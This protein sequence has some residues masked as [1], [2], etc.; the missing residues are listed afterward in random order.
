MCVLVL[1]LFWGSAIAAKEPNRAPV[2]LDGRP[3]FLVSNYGQFDADERAQAINQHLQEVI[4]TPDRPRVEVAK[5]QDK[6]KQSTTILVN[7]QH[8]MTVTERDVLPG[9]SPEKQAQLWA[10]QIETA[11]QQAQTYRT[12]A[13]LQ[14]SLLLSVMVGAIALFFHWVIGRWWRSLRPALHALLPHP[15]TD[16]EPVEYSQALD[17]LLNLVLTFIRVALWLS[18]AFYITNRFPLTRQWGYIIFSVLMTSFTSPVL[19]LANSAYS[20]ADLIVLI[21]MLFGLVIFSKIFTDFVKT[22]V[23]LMTGVNR[24]AREALAIVIRYSL[25]FVGSLVFLQIW[26]LDISSLTILASALSVGVGF[27]LQDIAKNF[28]SGLVL[29]FERPIQ[30][31]D[32]VEVGR[33]QGTIERIGARSTVIRTLDQISIIVPNSRFLEEEVI[34][35]SHDNP[36]SRLHL[37]LGVAYGSDIEKV[38]SVLLEAAKEQTGVLSI[39][40]P[41]VFFKGFGD[42]SLDFELLVWIA[43]PSKQLPLKSDL[44]FRIEALLR[45]NQV[46]IPFPQRDLNLRAGSVPIELSPQ[47]EEAFKRFLQSG[48]R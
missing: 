11:L 38:R 14:R 1:S 22:R 33:F 45:Q 9:Q 15:D 37:P 36:I 32:F 29:V 42:S 13:Y 3:L 8:L 24:G 5:S 43:E 34:N 26:G 41:Q 46:E 2:V 10:Q 21:G 20:I 39:P 31:G 28:G 47:L 19:T 7:R 18:V 4:E 6:N 35:W 23:L 30:V 17:L 48:L 44:Y 16:E 40:Q 27:G 25:I 12:T